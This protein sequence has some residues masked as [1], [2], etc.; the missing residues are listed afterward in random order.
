MR[1][2]LRGKCGTCTLLIY[3]VWNVEC[4]MWQQAYDNNCIHHH[5]LTSLSCSRAG[6]AGIER[7]NSS[8]HQ[9]DLRANMQRSS[10]MQRGTKQSR[11]AQDGVVLGAHSS[12]N[13]KFQRN[14]SST[15][16][17]DG[18][19]SIHSSPESRSHSGALPHTDLSRPGSRDGSRPES[20]PVSA[21]RDNGNLSR[22]PSGSGIDESVPHGAWTEE[23]ESSWPSNLSEH[24]AAH[25]TLPNSASGSRTVSAKGSRRPSIEVAA[26]DLHGLEKTGSGHASAV[27]KKSHDVKSGSMTSS[28]N[29]HV[30]LSSNEVDHHKVRRG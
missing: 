28:R 18:S 23:A 3:H 13:E 24:N 15:A 27:S 22:S 12:T 17:G 19:T 26:I 9:H 4:G 5:T 2:V 30:Q 16:A 20:R 6:S 7:N 11:N 14:N 8:S 1:V 21:L 25:G 29:K 10:S